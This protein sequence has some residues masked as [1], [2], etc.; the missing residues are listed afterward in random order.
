MS[1]VSEEAQFEEFVGKLIQQLSSDSDESIVRNGESLQVG[2]VTVNLRSNFKTFIKTPTE[3]RHQCFQLI[4]DVVSDG[5]SAEEFTSFEEVRPRLRPKL[6]SRWTFA[7]LALESLAGGSKL[8]SMPARLLGEHVILSF[9]VDSPS[10]MRP[11]SL[12]EFDCWGLAFD[13][14]LRAA[15]DNLV[16]NWQM[17][18]SKSKDGGALHCM[19]AADD[20]Y[21]SSR[22]LCEEAFRDFGSDYPRWVFA[23]SRDACVVGRHDQLAAI[24]SMGL[25]LA[26]DDPKPLPP[27]PLIDNGDGWV[28]WFPD[29]EDPSFEKLVE[30]QQAYLMNMYAQQRILLQRTAT[31]R[32]D[33][34]YVAEFKK[35]DDPNPV[36]STLTHWNPGS[37]ILLPQA[38][39]VVFEEDPHPIAWDRVLD[40]CSDFLAPAE[41][42]YPQ[43]WRTLGYPTKEQ[44]NRMTG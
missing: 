34:S 12:R 19:M 15:A 40:V 3:L 27:F 22:F 29:K 10:S 16:E 20:N 33:F 14:V 26:K 38:D 6:W 11:V 43:R 5:A 35:L 31:A 28:G 21:D 24:V 32:K 4:A 37:E 30:E 23:S 25:D 39:F 36:S 42:I 1:D 8:E 44:F 9:V 41:A 2:I 7:S 18:V 13:D 17:L